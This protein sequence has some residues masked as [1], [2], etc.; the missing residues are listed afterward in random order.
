[1]PW[2][3]RPRGIREVLLTLHVKLHLIPGV[4]AT[5]SKCNLHQKEILLT[6]QHGKQSHKECSK[7]SCYTYDS[8][9]FL[10]AMVIQ[11]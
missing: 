1:M 11:V 4:K 3:L 2:Q 5:G 6:A 10:S 7:F 8:D 9:A